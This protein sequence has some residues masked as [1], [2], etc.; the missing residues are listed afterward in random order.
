MCG[1]PEKGGGFGGSAGDGSLSGYASDYFETA[2]DVIV[3]GTLKTVKVG[4][5]GLMVGCHYVTDEAFEKIV[6]LYH[7]ARGGRGNRGEKEEESR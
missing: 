3:D 7:A 4:K 2:G 1:I 5:R 6:R